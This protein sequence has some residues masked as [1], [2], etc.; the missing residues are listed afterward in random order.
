MNCVENVTV[1][2]ENYRLHSTAKVWS[3]S[4]AAGKKLIDRNHW[5]AHSSRMIEGN[6]KSAFVHNFRS[7]KIPISVRIFPMQFHSRN[8]SCFHTYFSS[9]KLLSVL[10]LFFATTITLLVSDALLVYTLILTC[11]H[12]AHMPR[13]ITSVCVFICKHDSSKSCQLIFTLLTGWFISAS[14]W[15][16]IIIDNIMIADMAWGCCWL[17]K[18]MRSIPGALLVFLYDTE[19]S[20]IFQYTSACVFICKHDGSKSC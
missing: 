2:V 9:L 6:Q 8:S 5:N 16:I 19:D 12:S 11:D 4:P 7:K 20:N 3:I 10:F 14:T 17:G 1:W 18:G 15:T 13:T